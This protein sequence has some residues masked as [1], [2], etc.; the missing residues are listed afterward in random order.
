MEKY[1]TLGADYRAL[2]F[3]VA[4]ADFADQIGAVPFTDGVQIGHRW[5]GE[6]FWSPEDDALEALAARR[7]Q[8]IRDGFTFNGQSITLD[9]RTQS[10][11]ANAITGLERKPGGATVP[12]EL[13]RGEFIQ[14]DLPTLQAFGDAAF[15]H[16]QA[17]FAHSETISD[18][19]KAGEDY[20]L[21]AGWP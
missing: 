1:V 17:C 9:D 16:V 14:M 15:D 18:Q 7:W 11:I 19:I 10:R 3:I 12:W 20:D 6:R 21:E 8:A 5:D 2:N 13:R 4:D